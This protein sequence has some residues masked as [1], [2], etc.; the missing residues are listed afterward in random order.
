M[1]M[2]S[3]MTSKVT[4]GMTLEVIPETTPKLAPEVTMEVELVGSDAKSV[5][6][7]RN[8]HKEH[9]KKGTKPTKRDANEGY[10]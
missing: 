10:I 5:A 3:K 8:Q 6:D 2:T 1:E 4:T 9:P 7:V